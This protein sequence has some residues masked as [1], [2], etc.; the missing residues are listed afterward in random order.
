M[1]DHSN[2][3]LLIDAAEEVLA[4]PHG[5][6]P[7]PAIDV[8]APAPVPFVVPDPMPPQP[9][10]FS[11][12][13]PDWYYFGRNLRK[14]FRDACRLA[15]RS[16][17]QEIPNRES[18]NLVNEGIRLHRLLGDAMPTVDRSR[19]ENIH[20]LSVLEAQ[21]NEYKE[22]VLMA[23]S[24]YDIVLDLESTIEISDSEPD[25]EGQDYEEWS[26]ESETGSAGARSDVGEAGDDV[27]RAES[28]TSDGPTFEEDSDSDYEE[29]R[30]PSVEI[31]D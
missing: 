17:L 16:G 21:C 19:E 25:L 2:L 15:F 5:P 3:L 20:E 4:P 23:T 31:L 27:P 24:A 7:E 9:I 22:S 13:M 10:V 14:S 18:L 6:A 30:D 28:E 29:R 26:M 1:A 8:Q 11:S 12:E